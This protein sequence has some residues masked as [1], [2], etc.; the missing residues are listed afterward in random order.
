M[1]SPQTLLNS[2]QRAALSRYTQSS[3]QPRLSDPAAWLSLAHAL[4]R[5][6]ATRAF[7]DLL[8]IPPRRTS[9]TSHA[10]RMTASAPPSVSTPDIE[11]RL[12]VLFAE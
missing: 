9:V 8:A 5:A 10:P 2:R 12:F 7:D 3:N 6:A 1:H 11:T 4:R